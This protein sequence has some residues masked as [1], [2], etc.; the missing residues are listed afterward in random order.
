M[1][2]KKGPKSASGSLT[3]GQSPFSIDRIE[4]VRNFVSRVFCEDLHAK[5]LL[6]LADG[7]LWVV[8]GA[9]LAVAMIGHALAQARL[10][11]DPRK[12]QRRRRLARRARGFRARPEIG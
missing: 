6:S 3:C 4:T 1:G 9:S 5:R 8:T 11:C 2:S 7:A 10:L 12:P